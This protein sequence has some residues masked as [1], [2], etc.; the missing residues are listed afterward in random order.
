[1]PEKC[2]NREKIVASGSS[3]IPGLPVG[4]VRGLLCFRCFS[5][6]DKIMKCAGCKRAGY[7]SK[8]CQKLDWSVVHKKRCKVLAKVNEWD[9]RDYKRMSGRSI[10][11]RW[12]DLFLAFGLRLSER[13]R[14]MGD[15]YS[16]NTSGMSRH[17]TRMIMCGS[18]YSLFSLLSLVP[19]NVR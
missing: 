10:L 3:D 16:K 7:C 15:L 8:E 2:K 1:M 9:E 17:R 18:S 11:G 19:Y 4:A 12:Y 14:L 5:P 13:R 6:S